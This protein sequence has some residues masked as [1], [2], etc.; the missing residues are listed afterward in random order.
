MTA[1]DMKKLDALLLEYTHADFEAR[2]WQMAR[3][4]AR[5]DIAAFVESRS[6]PAGTPDALDIPAF[7][8]SDASKG[9]PVY[10][11]SAGLAPLVG[12][13]CEHC[14]AARSRATLGL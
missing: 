3:G 6:V 5:N 12:C 13:N 11:H 4:Q 1:D 7:L 14:A 2:R 9:S 8:R 10:P